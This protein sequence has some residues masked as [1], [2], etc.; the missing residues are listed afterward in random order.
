MAQEKSSPALMA[1]AESPVGGVAW[2]LSFKPQQW[3]E[4]FTA[5]V[6]PLATV[7]YNAQVC[8]LP[9]ATCAKM[10][11]PIGAEA[12]PLL[13]EPQ[14]STLPV[15]SRIAHVWCQPELMVPCLNS[16]P[17]GDRARNATPAGGALWPSTFDPQQ[18]AW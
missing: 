13:F 11:S 4:P 3:M 14:H 5:P 15:S 2:P 16:A 8:A 7:L 9:A 18:S 17:P 12:W 1:D 6:L 10:P